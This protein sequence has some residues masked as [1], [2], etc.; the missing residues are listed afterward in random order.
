F[1]HHKIFVVDL[2]H[3]FKL[4]IWKATLTH[5]VHLLYAVG[6]NRIQDFNA[7]FRDVPTFQHDTIHRFH[8]NVSGLK[9]L[10][11]RDFEDILQV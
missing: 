5:M 6:G 2:L 9:K 1:D 11:A 8:K 3:E 4:G 7:R 10:A